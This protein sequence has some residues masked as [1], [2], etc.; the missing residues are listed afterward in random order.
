MISDDSCW[1]CN[2]GQQQISAAYYG[3]ANC[4]ITVDSGLLLKFHSIKPYT[5]SGVN[6]DDV[7]VVRTVIGYLP[8]WVPDGT[9]LLVKC[10]YRNSATD[11]IISPF[12]IVM[13]HLS[14]YSSWTQHSN[15]AIGTGCIDF[16]SHQNERVHFPLHA[17]NG[18]CYYH[19][20]NATD[21]RT[22]N[23]THMHTPIVNHLNAAGLY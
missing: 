2:H 13:N 14:E 17:Q 7:A 20:T 5:I 12:D 21:Y 18:L 11:T 1:L 6:K 9:M 8:L 15:L 10:Y 23:N 3:G 16:I 4:S 22:D 19:S